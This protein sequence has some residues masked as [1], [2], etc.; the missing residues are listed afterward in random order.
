MAKTSPALPSV[1][2]SEIHKR[3]ALPTFGSSESGFHCA[4]WPSC[5]HLPLRYWMEILV[6]LRTSPIGK[7]FESCAA[8]GAFTWRAGC[9][10][11][12]IGGLAAPVG[13]VAFG[14][15]RVRSPV[16]TRRVAT[17]GSAEVTFIFIPGSS[18]SKVPLIPLMVVSTEGRTRKVRTCPLRIAEN[19]PAL[20][21][22]WAIS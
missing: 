4:M 17:P 22:I 18:S 5:F 16:A 8:T 13:A 6:P 10:L 3:L 11:V 12:P 15:G 21:S 2:G 19:V 7:P 14:A 9:A 20:A 1:A